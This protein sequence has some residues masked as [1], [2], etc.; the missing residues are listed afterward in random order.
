MGANAASVFSNEWNKD[1]GASV[2]RSDGM[3]R[4]PI[5]IEFAVLR[6]FSGG[7]A[8]YKSHMCEC[9]VSVDRVTT[10]SM[11][12]C[13][14]SAKKSQTTTSPGLVASA[15]VTFMPHIT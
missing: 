13:L 8:W 4:R 14:S 10:A 11:T 1:M 12:R 7:V 2:D 6:V 3:G 9:G 15:N 5:N